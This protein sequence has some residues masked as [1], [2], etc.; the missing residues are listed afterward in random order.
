VEDL[1]RGFILGT[2]ATALAFAILTFLLKP[3][4]AYEGDIFPGLI[5]LALIAGLVNGL[6][7]PIVNLLALPVRLATLGLISFVINAIMLLLVA[8]LS[9]LLD[10]SFTVGGFPP[11][12]GVDAILWAI[13][14]SIVLSIINAVIGH[15]VPD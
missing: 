6:V 4:I 2:L 9:S 3:N 12:F 5:I 15:F 13:V 11:D 14:G 7:K 1:M 10:I 8:W